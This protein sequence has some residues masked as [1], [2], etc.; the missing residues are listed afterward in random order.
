MSKNFKELL[1]DVKAFALDVDGVLTDGSII[2]M[3]DGNNLRKLNIKD[4]YAIQLGI[5]KGLKVAII[6]RSKSETLKKSLKEIGV[7]DI[8]LGTNDKKESLDEFILTYNLSPADILYMGDDIP[9]YEAMK[10]AGVPT[11]PIDAAPE[12]RAICLYTSQKKGGEGCVRDVIEQVLK[13]Q[14]KWI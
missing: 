13:V 11:C 4:C 2:L 6:T 3:P 5:S 9:D 1:R 12:I 7:N 10:Y 8:Y 14:G